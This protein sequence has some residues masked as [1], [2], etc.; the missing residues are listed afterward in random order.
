MNVIYY[1][2]SLISLVFI[3]HNTEK[4]CTAF[5]ILKMAYVSNSSTCQDGEMTASLS[6]E[7]PVWCSSLH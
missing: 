6:S 1:M 4:T 7:P 2:V 5:I 3:Y